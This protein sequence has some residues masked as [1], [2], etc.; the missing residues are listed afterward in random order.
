[1]YYKKKGEKERKDTKKKEKL[2]ESR[3]SKVTK[4]HNVYVNRL[5]LP[6]GSSADKLPSLLASSGQMKSSIASLFP[7]SNNK[8]GLLRRREGLSSKRNL[9]RSFATEA[10]DTEQKGQSQR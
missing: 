10:G 1:M 4:M 9:A 8:R 7:A 3:G 2:S 5:I 6:A